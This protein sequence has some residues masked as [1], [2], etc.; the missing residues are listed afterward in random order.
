MY[1]VT[2][3]PQPKSVTHPH[4]PTDF[5]CSSFNQSFH[6]GPTQVC[7]SSL[8]NHSTRHQTPFAPSPTSIRPLWPASCS[9]ISTGE[10]KTYEE[11]GKNEK[12]HEIPINLS[13]WK[14]K[15]P[16]SS[17]RKREQVKKN[18]VG[19]RV[20]DHCNFSP[21]QTLNSEQN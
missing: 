1:K 19:D 9:V 7:G 10:R 11:N 20:E 6:S 3:A 2:T 5:L 14:R 16:N 12:Q 15:N 4:T 17:C 13:R 8:H 21:F 18:S